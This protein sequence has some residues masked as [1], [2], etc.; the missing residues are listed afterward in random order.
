MDK[1]DCSKYGATGDEHLS[2]DLFGSVKEHEIHDFDEMIKLRK[3]QGKVCL[4]L[5]VGMCLIFFR[6]W[7]HLFF[8]LRAFVGV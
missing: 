7:I 4:S 6:I 2:T 1:I 3:I 8:V 5:R